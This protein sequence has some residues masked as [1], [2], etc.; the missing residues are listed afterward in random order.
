MKCCVV[1]CI[2]MRELGFLKDHSEGILPLF[3]WAAGPGQK[4][5]DSATAPESSCGGGASARQVFDP[6]PTNHHMGA[7]RR[8]NVLGAARTLHTKVGTYNML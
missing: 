1:D 5:G 8:Q 7:H 3:R 2:T 4:A 6:F